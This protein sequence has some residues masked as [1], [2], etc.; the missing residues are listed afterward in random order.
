[1]RGGTATR[2]P[3]LRGPAWR[4][5]AWLV[6]AAFLGPGTLTTAS[7][8]GQATGLGLLWALALSLTLTAGLQ[9]LLVH[10]VINRRQ[11][12]GR[13]IRETLEPPV[14]RWFSVT[15]TALAIGFGNAAYQAGN[16]TG[17]ALGL[18]A[19]LHLPPTLLGPGLAALAAL[20]LLTPLRARLEGLLL[21]LIAVMAAVFCIAALA[22]LR[23]ELPPLT[24]AMPSG[25]VGTL[26]LALIGTTVVP[27]NL[28]LHG[29]ALLDRLPPLHEPG[30]SVDPALHQDARRD[31]LR[32]IAVGGLI[33]G[34]IL[35]LAAGSRADG[36]SL[37]R[38]A[39]P[40]Q[41]LL[42]AGAEPFLALGLFAAG[43]SSALTAPLAAAWALAGLLRWPPTLEDPRTRITAFMVL[44][45]GALGAALGGQPLQMILLAQGANALALPWFAFLLLRLA[46]LRSESSLLRLGPWIVLAGAL[47]LG[48]A[49][50]FALL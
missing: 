21:G 34:A 10:L 9:L 33:T 6:T 1:M 25:K 22:S 12:L 24:L 16:L 11:D 3:A 20:L 7:L 35:L 47:G 50:L 19:W 39:S 31:T 26:A 28:F 40:L 42:G 43:L 46:T 27:Y 38:L 30:A 37:E 18:G 44:V 48:G 13:L 15:L 14:L 17:A 5:P 8:A 23:S 36:S 49:R 32:A 29:R 45:V 41:P 4:G 2:G